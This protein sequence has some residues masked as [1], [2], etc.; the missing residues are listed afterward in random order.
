MFAKCDYFESFT[1][2]HTHKISYGEHT[3][4]HNKYKSNY[5]WDARP[6]AITRSQS[7]NKTYDKETHL[8]Q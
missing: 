3:I 1:S 2:L 6:T 4:T 7:L 5:S 8:P